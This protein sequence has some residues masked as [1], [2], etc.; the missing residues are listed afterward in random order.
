M[1]PK[2]ASVF[3]ATFQTRKRATSPAAN[4]IS[5]QIAKISTEVRQGKRLALSKTGK[6][7]NNASILNLH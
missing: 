7:L 5:F 2:A 1:P 3:L 6:V 4:L